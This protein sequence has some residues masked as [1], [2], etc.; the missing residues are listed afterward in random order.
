MYLE[1]ETPISVLCPWIKG[2]FSVGDGTL[3]VRTANTVFGVFPAG[4]TERRIPIST[5]SGCIKDHYYDVGGML[6]GALLCFLG[7]LSLTNASTIL[8]ALFEMFLGAA[9]I[10]IS[11]KTIIRIQNNG[12]EMA[13]FIPFYAVDKADKAKE[14]IDKAIM[15]KAQ[16]D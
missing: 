7:T 10:A 5:I 12:T 16:N 6:T 9:F 8:F 3:V 11:V 13:V 1:V 2:S 14:M 15:K 4:M